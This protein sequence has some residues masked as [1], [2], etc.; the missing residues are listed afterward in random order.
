MVRFE[1]SS[2]GSSAIGIAAQMSAISP[3]HLC[4]QYC[5]GT[6]LRD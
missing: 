2:R 3:L 5:K 4:Q 6:E 1:R